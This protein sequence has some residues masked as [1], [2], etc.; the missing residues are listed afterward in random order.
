MHLPLI[1]GYG[2]INSGGI[3]ST[4][5]AYRNIVAPE[6]STA[7]RKKLYDSLHKLLMSQKESPKSSS[8]TSSSATSSSA[9]H[10][11]N[12]DPAALADRFFIRAIN[13]TNHFD[14][15]TTSY[16]RTNGNS[17]SFPISFAASLPDEF[18]PGKLYTSHNHPRSLQMAV[19]AANDALNSA[20]LDIPT[21]RSVVAPDKLAVYAGNSLG[22]LDLAGM[23][24]VLTSMLRRV[25][26]IT[27]QLPF[28][29]PQMSADFVNAY[30]L[31]NL[32]QT[33]NQCG[34]CATFLYNLSLAAHNIKSGELSMA[35]VGTSEAP[36]LPQL[37]SAF[38]NMGAMTSDKKLDVSSAI[39]D[40]GNPNNPNNH[41]FSKASLPFGDNS[42]FVMGE[43][44]QFVILASEEVACN[45][46]ATI[47]GAVP[48]VFI[49]ADGAKRSISSPGPGNY[50]TMGKAAYAAEKLLGSKTLR[51]SSYVH[52]HGTSTPQNRVTESQILS[53]VAAAFGI[54]DWN[55]L[56]IKSYLGHSQATAGG[57]QLSTAL[58]F[59]KHGILPGISTVQHL[60]TD[61]ATEN[62][63]FNLAHNDIGVEAMDVALINA[64]GF[65]G[66]NATAL[67]LSP[68]Q[69]QAMYKKLVGSKKIKRA[70]PQREKTLARINEYISQAESGNFKVRYQL[71]DIPTGDNEIHV[72]RKGI[73][74]KGYPPIE[75]KD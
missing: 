8:T 26:T 60:A 64:K 33:G 25:K 11:I 54:K 29:Y 39:N 61:V 47:H 58:G 37:M 45:L 2:G 38:Y 6:L 56:A 16:Y 50:I 40:K 70:I 4:D 7:A 72:T 42:G 68:Q 65:G 48:D 17:E 31:N 5:Q 57:D 15:Q 20:G 52:A 51:K 66:N 28:S 36:I 59:W 35:V 13:Q 43:S 10:S 74:I 63:R 12:K 21:I 55:V 49:S 75:F 30:V 1:I 46:G 23:G 14:P 27:K 18:N 22:Q 44:A 71:A 62:L 24:G 41:D 19:F 67:L 3:S 32:G 73:E 9:T 53:S 34:A 69:A